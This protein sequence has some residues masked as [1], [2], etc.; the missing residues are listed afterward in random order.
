MEH[1]EEN[2]EAAIKM[3]EPFIEAINENVKIKKSKMTIVDELFEAPIKKQDDTYISGTITTVI[4]NIIDKRFELFLEDI[5]NPTNIYK[6]DMP[7]I[8]DTNEYIK[9]TLAQVIDNIIIKRFKH[10]DYDRIN[11]FKNQINLYIEGLSDN[12]NNEHYE[13]ACRIID[14]IDW[15]KHNFD[16]IRFKQYIISKNEVDKLN[17]KKKPNE[18]YFILDENLNIITFEKL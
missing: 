1:N 17:K 12:I 9:G 5:I 6:K 7:E 15:Y 18:P 16:I 4:N 11:N 13:I 8:R 2:I 14:I 10:F 3:V